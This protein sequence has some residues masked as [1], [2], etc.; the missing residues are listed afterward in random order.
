M[1]LNNKKNE[2]DKKNGEMGQLKV[3][4][5]VQIFDENF[6]GSSTSA[7]L[8]NNSSFPVKRG[9]FHHAKGKT[10]DKADGFIGQQWKFVAN[11]EI[12]GGKWEKAGITKPNVEQLVEKK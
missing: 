5:L 12:A 8:R 1:N 2:N 9:Q 4:A 7:L 3:K 11:R 10:R 6:D